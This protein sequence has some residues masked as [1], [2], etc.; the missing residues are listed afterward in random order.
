[1]KSDFFGGGDL[2]ALTILGV[3]TA[4]NNGQFL[5]LP[6]VCIQGVLGALLTMGMMG[7]SLLPTAEY[8]EG[9][10][11]PLQAQGSGAS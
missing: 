10:V 3:H 4:C 1:M 9:L 7:C 6:C 2:H 11:D 5:H 8:S